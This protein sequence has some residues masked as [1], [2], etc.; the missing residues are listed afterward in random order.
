MRAVGAGMRGVDAVDEGGGGERLRGGAAARAITPRRRRAMG[1]CL[2]NTAAIAAR[3]AQKVHGLE[4]V[5]IVDWDVHHGNGTQ[6]IFWSDPSVLYASTHQ[7]P[8]FPGTGAL[9][10]TGVG[11]IFNAPLSPGDGGDRFREA[12]EERVLPALRDFAAGPG[13]RLRRVRRAS[14]RPAGLDRAG[15]G[16][17][18]L[19]DR[20]ADGHR[21]PDRGRAARRAPGGRLRP[22]GVGAIGERPYPAADD[23][24]RR[25][26][27]G[28]R[29][30]KA[31]HPPTSRRSAS[32]RR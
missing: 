32:R 18:R 7:M 11:N 15:G 26:A 3:H 23:G 17:F 13:P 30:D 20:Q 16:R 22:E 12:F 21:R 14:P 8:L 25:Q 9:R 31:G 28:R 4:R 5:A 29:P 27:F 1:F 2:F 10:E 6:E 24:L 19:G